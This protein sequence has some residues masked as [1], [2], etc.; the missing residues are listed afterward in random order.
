M[1]ETI[2]KFNNE[3]KE[4]TH[5]LQIFEKEVKSKFNEDFFKNEKIKLFK[6]YNEETLIPEKFRKIEF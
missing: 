1:N 3:N 6:T 5:I 4:I 2:K